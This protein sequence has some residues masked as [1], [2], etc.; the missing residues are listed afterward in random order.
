MWSR[1]EMMTSAIARVQVAVVHVKAAKSTMSIQSPSCC[2]R[3]RSS[4]PNARGSGPHPL[5]QNAYT[6]GARHTAPF[7]AV[8]VSCAIHKEVWSDRTLFGDTR[9]CRRSPQPQPHGRTTPDIQYTPPT[10]A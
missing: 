9:L 6:R 10:G 1:A 4:G 8:S 2:S 5:S 7:A 3:D